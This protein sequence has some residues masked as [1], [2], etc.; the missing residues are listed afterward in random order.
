[1]PRLGP[2]APHQQLARDAVVALLEVLQVAGRPAGELAR[3]LCGR[4]SGRGARGSGRRAERAA[5]AAAFA[6]AG[7]GAR[8]AARPR[9][10]PPQPQLTSHLSAMTMK[11]WSNV[12]TMSSR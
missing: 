6:G 9:R 5:G 7:A 12:S 2:P 8:E 10:R 3:G 11:R 4:A 1:M